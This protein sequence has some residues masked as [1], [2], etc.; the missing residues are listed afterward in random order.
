MKLQSIFQTSC[1]FTFYTPFSHP[2]TYY[3]C[4]QPSVNNRIILLFRY[5]QDEIEEED[6]VN[7]QNAL[8]AGLNVEVLIFPIQRRPIDQELAFLVRTFERI[9]IDRFWIALEPETSDEE[10][11]WKYYSAEDNCQYLQDY[12]MKASELGMKMSFNIYTNDWIAAFKDKTA[13]P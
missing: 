3:K 10:C 4:I 1:L 12:V 2:T 5:Y 13:C 11:S 8:K 7:V 9:S 6:P